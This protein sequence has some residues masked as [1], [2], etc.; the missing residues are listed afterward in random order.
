MAITLP[1]RWTVD[2]G[3]VVRNY[4]YGDVDFQGVDYGTA[5][6]PPL[7]LNIL[8]CV[9]APAAGSG[10]MNHIEIRVAQTEIDVYATDAGVAHPRPRCV[11]SLRSPTQT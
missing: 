11:R 1:P 2:S 6:I 5:S 10:V 3:V 7:T 8:D 4:I 9:I